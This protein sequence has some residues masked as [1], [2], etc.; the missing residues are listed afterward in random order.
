MNAQDITS[1]LIFENFNN[2]KDMIEIFENRAPKFY[3]ICKN[4][5]GLNSNT[6][7]KIQYSDDDKN[8]G[9]FTVKV[10]SILKNSSSITI[11]LTSSGRYSIKL[12]NFILDNITL[13]Y[14]SNISNILKNFTQVRDVK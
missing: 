4:I 10:I 9:T 12:T 3:K 13:E 2:D 11:I 14:L 7:M 5:E 8:N 1:F 6:S